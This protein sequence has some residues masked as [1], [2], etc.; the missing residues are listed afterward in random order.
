MPHP[1]RGMIDMEAPLGPRMESGF[2][3]FGF[4]VGEAPLDPFG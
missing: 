4:Q 3:R 1:S 2:A